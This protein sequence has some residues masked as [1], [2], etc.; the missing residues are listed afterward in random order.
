[1]ILSNLSNLLTFFSLLVLKTRTQAWV[2][3]DTKLEKGRIHDG[4]V[5]RE[6]K[7]KEVDTRIKGG[8]GN[9]RTT[10]ESVKNNILQH[11]VGTVASSG[12]LLLAYIQ[13]FQ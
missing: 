13:M 2:R 8:I 6:L 11:V 12:A 10:L 7:I 4:L 1:M 9:L 3:S 5:L